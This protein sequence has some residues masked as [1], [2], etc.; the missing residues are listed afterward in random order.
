MAGDSQ[1]NSLLS[2]LSYDSGFSG[3]LGGF[4]NV[5]YGDWPDL[6]Q[7]NSPTTDRRYSMYMTYEPIN[8][9]LPG[10]NF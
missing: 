8:M 1:Y 3:E 7:A 4:H 9:L 10:C 2:Y 6:I 5:H